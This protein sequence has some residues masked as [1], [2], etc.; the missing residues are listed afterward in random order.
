MSEGTNG[1]PLRS[2]NNLEPKRD[3]Q[4]QAPAEAGAAAALNVLAEETE[5]ALG[6]LTAGGPGSWT[7][8][9]PWQLS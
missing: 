7:T 2:P 9:A 1:G 5:G 4:A 8:C 6:G 3:G